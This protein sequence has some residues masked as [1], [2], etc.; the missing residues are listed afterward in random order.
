M[1]DNTRCAGYS[2]LCLILVPLFLMSCSSNNFT[3]PQQYTGNWQTEKTKVTVR[4]ESKLLKF[5]FTTDSAV[6][7]IKIDDDKTVAGFIGSAEFKKGKLK[8]NYGAPNV[9]GVAYIIECGSIGKIFPHDPME[10][11]EVEIWL[12]PINE[13]GTI[14]AELRYTEGMEAFP[15]AGMIFYKVRS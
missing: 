8:K 6:I 10:A 7:S 2:S 13:N 9:T 3:V 11:K 5:Q 12:G 15:M 14:K 4:T 1:K